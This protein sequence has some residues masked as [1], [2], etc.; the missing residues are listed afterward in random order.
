MS[1]VFKKNRERL[2]AHD[3]LIELLNHVL[4]SADSNKWLSGEH[5]SADGTLVQAWASHKSFARKDGSDRDLGGGS[6]KG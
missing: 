5:F 3:A 1:T 2:L 4:Q 6:F